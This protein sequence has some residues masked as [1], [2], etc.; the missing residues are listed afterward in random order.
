MKRNSVAV[1]NSA[2]R[3]ATTFDISYIRYEPVGLCVRSDVGVLK[4]VLAGV[5]DDLR[6]EKL[7]YVKYEKNQAC[8]H[9]TV[10]K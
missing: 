6:E 1:K 2:H 3:Y 7:C 4:S 8:F 5:L 9:I 10:R